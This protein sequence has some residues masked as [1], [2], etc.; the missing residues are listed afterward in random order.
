MF[1]S[2][3]LIIALSPV[4]LAAALATKLTS[5]GPILFCQT[6][7]GRGGQPF[8]SLKFRTMRAEHRHDPKEIIPLTHQAITPV[9]RLLRRLKIDELPQLF[10][11]LKGDMSLVGP[12]PGSP[13]AT[14]ARLRCPRP[15]PVMPA[16]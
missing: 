5:P 15:T 12:R 6:R 4:W 8:E 16:R 3:L 1:V 7:G 14:D 9:G 11:V 13:P 10:N 2:A